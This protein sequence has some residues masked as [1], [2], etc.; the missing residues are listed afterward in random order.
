MKNVNAGGIH[1]TDQ[2]KSDLK[3]FLMT[4]TDSTF[5]NNPDFADPR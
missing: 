3:A 1:L 2:E 4:F 5:M